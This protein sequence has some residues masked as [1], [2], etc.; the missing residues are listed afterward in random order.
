MRETENYNFKKPDVKEF[1]ELKTWSDNL[2]KIDQE[3]KNRELAQ[4]ESNEQIE[5]MK[6]ISF[7][8]QEEPEELVKGETVKSAF[9]KLAAAVK[10]LIIH[11]TLQATDTVLGHVKLSNSAAITEKGLYALDAVEKNATVDGTLAKKI[12]ELNDGLVNISVESG[13]FLKTDG[14]R[15]SFNPV[16]DLNEFYKGIA[17]FN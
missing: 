4:E 11:K 12:S 14:S 9:G 1:F 17:L 2:D 3:I 6:K 13:N 10:T 15:Q 5:K 8:E 16:L 7:D